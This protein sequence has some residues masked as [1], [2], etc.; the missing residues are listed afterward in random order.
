MYVAAVIRFPTEVLGGGG[1]N[2][3][4]R[5]HWKFLKFTCY[6]VAPSGFLTPKKTVY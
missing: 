2:D 3:A 5:P 4:C 1:I 6:E